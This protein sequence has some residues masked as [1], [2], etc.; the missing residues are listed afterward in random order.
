MGLARVRNLIARLSPAGICDECLAGLV[1]L[2]KRSEAG[3]LARQLVGHDSYQ[4][5][6]DKC[7]M[8]QQTRQVTRKLK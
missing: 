7:C 3:N 5:G 6:R 8:C 1:E 2:S 4:R